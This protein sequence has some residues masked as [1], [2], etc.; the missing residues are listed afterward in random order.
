MMSNRILSRIKK[1]GI[2]PDFDLINT[3]GETVAPDKYLRKNNLVVFFFNRL[4]DNG[5][6]KYL[7]MLND[8]YKELQQEDTEIIAV[9]AEDLQALREFA[10]DKKIKFDLLADPQKEVLNKFTY[11]D[12]EVNNIGVLFIFDKYSTLY[13]CYFHRAWPFGELPDKNELISAIEF[14]D[15]QC[16][17]CGVSTW[18]E[19]SQ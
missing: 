6:K 8:I 10:Q 17:E 9:A 14:L 7:A 19:Y 2:M 5:C 1:G 3:R 4:D 11:K 18:P 13:R 16:P 15:K 12:N